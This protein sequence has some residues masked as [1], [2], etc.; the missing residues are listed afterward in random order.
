MLFHFFLEAT[1]IQKCGET[2]FLWKRSC[3]F[4]PD[5][6]RKCKSSHIQRKKHLK[7][8]PHYQ[9]W[10]HN[11]EEWKVWEISSTFCDYKT[12]ENGIFYHPIHPWISLVAGVR[13]RKIMQKCSKL[14][15]FFVKLKQL[16]SG[17][18]FFFNFCAWNE[19]SPHKMGYNAD[20]A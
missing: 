3:R 12:D 20:L 5:F 2:H 10:K 14:H 4:S 7:N 1:K 11:Y 8:F 18:I 15:G 17:C 16:E 19:I 6:Y 9:K 13:K